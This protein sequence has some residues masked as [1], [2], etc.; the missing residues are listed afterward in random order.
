[1]RTAEKGAGM[2]I[3]VPREIKTEEFRVG[4]SPLGV[5]ELTQERHTV[6][7]EA[8]AGTGSGFTDKEYQISG[9]EIADKQDLYRKADLVVKV[10]EPLSPEFDLLREGQAL[11]TYLHLAPNRELTETILKK[12]VTGLGYETLTR[13]GKL[14]LLAPMSEI[15]GRMAPLMGAYYLQKFKG[16]SGILATGAAG[17]K[18]AKI[19]ILGAGVVGTN[20]ARTASNLGMETVVMNK[21]GG[22]LRA[23]TGSCAGKVKT[24]PVT[25]Q[26][27]DREIRDADIIVGAVLV[28]GGKTPVLITRRMLGAMRKGSVIVDVAVDQGGCVETSKPTT[29]DDPVYGVDGIIHYCVANMPGAY[30]RTSTLALTNATLP[31]IKMIAAMGIDKAV[32]EDAIIRSALN[33]FRGKIMNTALAESLRFAA[34]E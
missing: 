31:Y 33:T 26:A 2:I 22:R 13:D 19:V 4:I 16:G 5:R 34:M 14:P 7:V 12:Q 25:A 3:G 8:G 24:V 15:A 28:P 17:V 20:A 1:M 6:L 9:A 11:F 32:Q 30:P 10:K 23:I 21:E 27:I 29:H 18:P